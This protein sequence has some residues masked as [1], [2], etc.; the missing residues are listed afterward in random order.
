MMRLSL[1]LLLSLYLSLTLQAAALSQYRV[2]EQIAQILTNQVENEYKEVV[3]KLY[4]H[5]EHQPL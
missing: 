3:A 2:S 4:A 5:S 1:I